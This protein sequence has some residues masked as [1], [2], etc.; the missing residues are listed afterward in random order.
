MAETILSALASFYPLAVSL[1][2]VVFVL[3]VTHHFLIGRHDYLSGDKKLPRQVTMLLLT[4]VAVLVIVLSLPV[5]EST[6]NQIIALIGVLLSGVIAFS[7]TTVVS[8]LMAG[9]VLRVNKPFRVG[10]FVRVNGFTGRV[11]QMGLL[12]TEIQSETRELIAFA[13]SLLVSSPVSV[14]RA[15]GAIISV[16]LS[17]GY[18]LHHSVVEK[19]LLLAA[20]RSQLEEPFVQVTALGDFSVTY[21]IAGLLKDVKSMLSARSNLHKSVMDCLHEAGIEIV[22]PS[23]MNQRP[24]EPGTQMIPKD[25]EHKAG[26]G[27]PAPESVVF[28]KAEQAES[29]IK[30][31]EAMEKQLSML[32]EQKHSVSG[33]EKDKLQQRI[34]TLTSRLEASEK[35]QEEAHEEKNEAH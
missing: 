6:R 11:T 12:D 24:Q 32:K 5:S 19:H 31:K 29:Q 16:D 14:V 25:R 3:S 17:L 27:S 18:E 15:S 10:D 26:N 23:F 9:I 13:N 35:Q 1:I 34:D 28:D 22:S 8:N 7:S 2:V 30:S 20:E 4:L 33:E 21:R